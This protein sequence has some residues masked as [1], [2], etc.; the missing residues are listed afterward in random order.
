MELLKHDECLVVSL[1]FLGCAFD[2]AGVSVLA[3]YLETEPYFE[4]LEN[5]PPPVVEE[6]PQTTSGLKWQRYDCHLF[7]DGARPERR[8]ELTNQ[9]LAS[10]LQRKWDRLMEEHEDDEVDASEMI[11]EFKQPEWRRFGIPCVTTDQFVEVEMESGVAFFIPA[12]ESDDHGG[13]EDE[14]HTIQFSKGIKTLVLRRA[15]LTS[16]NAYRLGQAL[17]KNKNLRVLDLAQNPKI[18]DAGGEKLAIFLHSHPRIWHL[19]LQDC[20]IG[21]C[22]V[23]KLR[24]LAYHRLVA[25]AQIQA[26]CG[27]DDEE[28]GDGLSSQKDLTNVSQE[29]TRT[30]LSSSMWKQSS[31][32][33][34][35]QDLT[36]AAMDEH[37]LV[38][39]QPGDGCPEI[40]PIESF[41]A[42]VGTLLMPMA[43]GALSGV[44]WQNIGGGRPTSG[45]E[46]KNSQLGKALQTK[47]VFS[48][49]EWSAFE[50]TDLSKD[51]FIKSGVSFFK[52]VG[53][54]TLTT[55]TKPQSRRHTEESTVGFREDFASKIADDMMNLGAP[56]SNTEAK[57][58]I[59]PAGHSNVL[60]SN[61]TKK[62]DE[63]TVAVGVMMQ[64]RKISRPKN[65]N[66]AG[67]LM[68]WQQFSAAP[69]LMPWLRQTLGSSTSSDDDSCSER[70]SE[71][72]RD[73]TSDKLSLDWGGRGTQILK[74]RSQ[75]LDAGMRALQAPRNSPLYQHEQV[76]SVQ[77]ITRS[78][79]RVVPAQRQSLGERA[80]RHRGSRSPYGRPQRQL[81]TQGEKE[82]RYKFPLPGGEKEAMALAAAA[83]APRPP[84]MMK[85]E[86]KARE[87]EQRRADRAARARQKK[88]DL[89][90][91]AFEDGLV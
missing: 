60:G 36:K 45:Q 89:L 4:T 28:K 66:L 64:E 81:L 78:V 49:Q 71:E 15:G 10:A 27:N 62:R 19:S 26:D 63:N 38:H 2:N 83:S 46:L 3:S 13:E 73:M 6:E 37:G 57:S 41:R 76:E 5:L 34:R 87:R 48:T 12:N 68:S 9:A 30:R 35:L 11:L 58:P 29:L 1:V 23:E 18:G 40:L 80:V 32:R 51:H 82:M 88:I 53:L 84:K 20:N 56:G 47:T 90:E 52:P 91:A 8:K 77:R 33:S 79:Q 61:D 74:S 22:G 72:S 67:P 43:I 54:Q 65:G 24:I 31:T 75:V 69:P 86:R 14:S 70:Q 16:Q 21:D 50:I 25:Q 44:K 55:E 42:V 39:E 85:E 7:V 17:E 59:R